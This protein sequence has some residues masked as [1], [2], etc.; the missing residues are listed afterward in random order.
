MAYMHR[1]WDCAALNGR[2]EAEG[3]R[4]EAR[5]SN[6]EWHLVTGLRVADDGL[7]EA[8]TPLG[9][10]FVVGAIYYDEAGK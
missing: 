9:R 8:R 5:S 3:L 2:I 6:G 10:W 7:R 4:I 1:K